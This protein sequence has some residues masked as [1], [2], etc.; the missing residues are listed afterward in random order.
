LVEDHEPTR[1]PLAGLL[2]RRGYDVVAVGSA[3]DAVTAAA[4]GRFD[5]VLSDIGLPDHDGFWLMRT[6]RERHGSVGIALT[7]YGMDED[8]ARSREAGFIDHLTKP[9]RVTVLDRALAKVFTAAK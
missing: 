6:L 4:A 5:L 2:V 1:E 9:I 8:L 7:G 3:E